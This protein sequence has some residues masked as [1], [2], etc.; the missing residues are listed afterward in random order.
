MTTQPLIVVT[1][2]TR[3]IGLACA[4]VLLAHGFRVHGLSRHPPEKALPG[5]FEWSSVDL[6][7]RDAIEHWAGQQGKPI[8]ALLNNAGRW[9]EERVDEADR[10]AWNAIMR[11]NLD[12]VYFLTKALQQR[13]S[14]GGRVVNVAS[15]LGTAGRAAYGPYAASKHAVIGLTRCWALELAERAIT[16]NA[17]CPGWVRTE[18]NLR[19]LAGVAE[20]RGTSLGEEL[21]RTASGLAL[22]RFIQ[23]E[24]VAQLVAFLISP[25]ASGITGQVYEI[26]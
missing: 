10:G 19:E 2:S 23:P 20:Q 25:D 3:G 7:S 9:I 14:D 13:I 5:D 11:L 16:V 17:V 24:E 18:S 1:G 22:L 12:G 4:R 26:K 6:S 21:E 8:H 15:Q